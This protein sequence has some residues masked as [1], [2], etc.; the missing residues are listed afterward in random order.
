MRICTKRVIKFMFFP[1]VAC[2]LFLSFS[3]VRATT[4]QEDLKLSQDN[5]SP[6]H[7]LNAE[8]FS[9]G[10]LIVDHITDSHEWHIAGSHDQAIS[11]PLPV[12]L[13]SDKGLDIFLS[14]A[15]G[16]GKKT[17][18]GKNLYRIDKNTIYI[19]NPDGS[20]NE[21]ATSKLWD[22]SITKNVLS[23]FVSIAI[24]LWI[25]ISI[26]KS[27]TRNPN[28]P[29]S[30]MQSLLEP[31][32]IFVRDEIAKSNIG[33][34]HYRKYMP[35]LLTVFFFIWINN[36]LGLIPVFPGGANLTGNI[37]IPMTLAL[38]VLIITLFSG[39]K[40]YW[41][42]IFA[43]PGVPVFVIFILTPI[44]ILGVILKPF[45]LMVRLFANILAGHIIALSF[46]CLIFI[47]AELSKGVGFG[48]SIFTVAFTVFMGML[49]LLVGF[50]QAYVFTML[51]ATYFGAAVEEHGH[52]EAH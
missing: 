1:V 15:F 42:H 49:E 12:I 23:L 17:V 10:E 4:T 33:E 2:L 3:E 8:K 6:E 32:I 14:S 26:A 46:F 31:L 43:M 21:E 47:F 36:L 19:V 20:K 24:M 41:R 7:N 45:V 29:P 27:Y 9:A 28:T 50:I 52:A 18:E 39:N 35:F 38:V 30:G 44:E 34:K 51:S 5:R 16:H 37:A 40:H 25:F 48:V 13:F 22:I 11:I